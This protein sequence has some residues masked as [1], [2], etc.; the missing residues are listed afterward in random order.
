MY[1]LIDTCLLLT[2]L[3]H[4]TYD[5]YWQ[6]DMPQSGH[7]EFPAIDLTKSTG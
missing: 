7:L 1:Y 5:Y 3:D 4:M 2:L 6:Y